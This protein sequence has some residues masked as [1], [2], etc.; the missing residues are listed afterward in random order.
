MGMAGASAISEPDQKEPS[1]PASPMDEEVPE[2]SDS[3]QEASSPDEEAAPP[4][5]AEGWEIFV[6]AGGITL[7]PELKEY[8][9]KAVGNGEPSAIAAKIVARLE[10][11]PTTN[12]G[13]GSAL[14]LDGE[15][16]ESSA[17]LVDGT[18]RSA[19]VGGMRKTQEPIVL[20][21][22]LFRSGGGTIWGP[23]ADDLAARFD[24]KQGPLEVSRARADYLI[25]LSI[26]VQ[27][28]ISKELGS[29]FSLYVTPEA[30]TQSFTVRASDRSTSGSR[31]R[32]VF[33]LVVAPDDQSAVAVSHGGEPLATPGSRS[34][35]ENVGGRAV[36]LK[37]SNAALVFSA[38]DSCDKSASDILE[39]LRMTRSLALAAQP[40]EADCSAAS[41]LLFSRQGYKSNLNPQSVLQMSGRPAPAAP[42]AAPPASPAAPRPVTGPSPSGVPAPRKSPAKPPTPGTTKSTSSAVAPAPQ[43]PAP[44]PSGASSA[45]TPP[46]GTKEAS[47]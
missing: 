2:A 39:R 4:T 12:A 6:F 27:A 16:I 45:G 32:P 15:T 3:P 33:A 31:R 11:L 10:A 42:A 22:S 47:P 5:I 1:Q 23:A 9:R 24:L 34:K 17:L 37:E 19:A 8:A 41:Y 14:R 38:A 26:A 18:G 30:L 13:P 46:P 25:D 28:G 44:A 36:A 40:L 21:E 7:S 20:A 35:I 43:A 29:L